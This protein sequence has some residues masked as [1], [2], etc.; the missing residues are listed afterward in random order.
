MDRRELLTGSDALML[1]LSISGAALLHSIV[2]A[3][4]KPV[5]LE[6]MKSPS[7]YSYSRILL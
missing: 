3:A 4:D 1:C 5:D 2:A 7:S 6:T